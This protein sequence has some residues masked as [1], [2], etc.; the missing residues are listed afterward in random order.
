MFQ[1]R[2]VKPRRADDATRWTMAALSRI[3]TYATD[4]CGCPIPSR[5]SL[6]IR[7][8]A[9]D[10]VLRRPSPGSSSGGPWASEAFP[11]VW[12][13]SAR[14]AEM[15]FVRN[16]TKVIVA[17][18]FFVVVTATF[19]KLYVFVIMEIET[20]RILHQNVTA[21][22][23]RCRR[24]GTYLWRADTSS[25]IAYR[26]LLCTKR[27]AVHTEGS[28]NRR[29]RPCQRHARQIGCIVVTI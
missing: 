18:D 6:A 24:H 20:R 26:V 22:V 11:L 14:T 29:S 5:D 21:L 13:S 12:T 19:R 25:G 1:E 16:H 9:P 2:K 28:W 8:L 23:D 27:E 7:F 4:R 17:C 3:S 15:T 10:R